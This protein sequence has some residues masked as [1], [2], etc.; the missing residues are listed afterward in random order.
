[1][2]KLVKINQVAMMWY[3]IKWEGSISNEMKQTGLSSEKY[4]SGAV[5]A[6]RRRRAVS[7]GVTSR[8]ACWPQ[9]RVV[10]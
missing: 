1:M 5:A 7:R 9:L 10:G 8:H 4:S 6:T 2:E 3:G